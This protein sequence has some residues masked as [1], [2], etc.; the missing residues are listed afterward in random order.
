MRPKQRSFV[1]I[2]AFVVVAVAL[3]MGPSAWAQPKYKVL[4]NIDGGLWSGLTFDSKGNLYGVTTG[5]GEKGVGSVFEMTRNSKG[6]WT[7]TTLHSFDGTDGSSPN[8]NLIFDAA[9][10][11]YGTTPEGGT[12]DGGTVFELTPSSGGWTF[13]VLYNFC[14][15]YGCP[16]GGGPWAG[17]TLGHTGDLYGTARGG[18]P[19]YGGT[20]FELVTGSG[21][22]TY[23]VLH[24]FD[25]EN[26]GKDGGFPYAGLTLSDAST[27]YGTT[28]SGGMYDLGTIFK[29]HKSSDDWGE[30]LLW[31]FDGSSGSWSYSWGCYRRFG[32]PVRYDPWR[33][34]G[35]RRGFLWNGVQADPQLERSLGSQRTVWLP[36]ATGWV[37]ADH[38]GGS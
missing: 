6:K 13:G 3:A 34:R 17:L 10:N 30:K 2:N 22:W 29:L 26:D 18:G 23:S 19:Y 11:L 15:Q 12:Y 24:D 25:G 14:E 28:A 27:L 32:K 9:G 37:R 35:L 33:R 5:G 1:V 16:E 7:V 31:Q 36:E 21:G 4:A 8:G 20:A 38:R